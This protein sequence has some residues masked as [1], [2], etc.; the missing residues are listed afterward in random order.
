MADLVAR[1]MAQNALSSSGTISLTK[2]KHLAV[3]GNWTPAIKAAFDAGVAVGKTV[4]IPPG[5]YVINSK[6]TIRIP[7]GKSLQVVGSGIFSMIKRKAG[8]ITADWQEMIE[9]ITEGTG[10]VPLVALSNF[11]MDANHMENPN[12]AG[13]A[14]AY[15]HCAS[16]RFAGTAS[17]YISHLDLTHLYFRDAVDADH[18]YIS[19]T[20]NSFI[21]TANLSHIYAEGRNTVR[22]DITITGGLESINISNCVLDSLEIELNSP[23]DGTGASARGMLFTVNN[24]YCR[25]N[26][27]I[28]GELDEKNNTIFHA[29]NLQSP[30]SC[31]LRCMSGSVE[32]SILGLGQA[33][34][35]R[36]LNLYNFRFHNVTFLLTPEVGNVKVPLSTGPYMYDVIF[37][38]CKF[39]IDSPDPALVSATPLLKFEPN[40]TGDSRV[41]VEDCIFDPRVQFCIEVDRSGKVVL[42]NNRYGGT[43]Y[44]IK[45][46]ASA[47]YP[48]SLTID[49]GDFNDVIGTQFIRIVSGDSLT[50]RLKNI[51]VAGA[52]RNIDH[53][54]TSVQNTLLYNERVIWVDAAPTAGGLKGDR[55]ILRVPVAGQA[56]EWVATATST[57][58]AVWKVSRTLGT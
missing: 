52:H 11:A 36:Q 24:V 35:G 39:L 19:G 10:S 18:I 33:T 32:N 22:S 31:I 15:E 43:L 56:C 55:A 9:I 51:V 27:D 5:L 54:N 29:N 34:D 4:F 7:A 46:N 26:L 20:T 25:K 49:G 12:N 47:T 28:A 45:V 44:P 8:Y 50:L 41:H 14:Y 37:S 23:Y 53:D 30:N 42:K 40:G 1:A 17:N 16:L 21:R 58:N 57:T 3:G 13:N 38:S 2:Y 6:V 48:V